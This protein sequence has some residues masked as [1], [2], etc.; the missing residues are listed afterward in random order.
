MTETEARGAHTASCFNQAVCCA[1][2]NGAEPGEQ[3]Y[4]WA[5]DYLTDSVVD[6]TCQD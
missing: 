5:A 1:I 3:S 2:E 4:E 6:C